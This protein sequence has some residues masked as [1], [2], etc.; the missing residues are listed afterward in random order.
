M[1]KKHSRDD[2]EPEFPLMSKRMGENYLTPQMINYH[3]A[4]IG[5]LYATKEGGH[6]IA[7]PRYYRNKIYTDQEQKRQLT[8]IQDVMNQQEILEMAQYNQVYG[9]DNPFTYHHWKESRRFGRYR[10]FTNHNK[11]QRN[12]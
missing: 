12:L 11:N 1:K 3:K 2:R 5:R 9:H 8:F 7:L 6:R 4:D 10:A